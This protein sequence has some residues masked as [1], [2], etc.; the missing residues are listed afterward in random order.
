VNHVMPQ[1]HGF[2]SQTIATSDCHMTTGNMSNKLSK[3]PAGKNR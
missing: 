1:N 3:H 2:Q